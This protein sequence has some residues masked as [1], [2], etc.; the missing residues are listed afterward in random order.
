MTSNGG[1][2]ADSEAPIPH[3]DKMPEITSRP[4]SGRRMQSAESPMILKKVGVLS[5]AKMF[6]AVYA[7]LGLVI[8]VCVAIFSLL[9]SAFGA[10][11]QAG[12][13]GVIFGVGAVIFLPILYGVL[14]F[15]G[16][17]LCAFLY[18]V[19]S[20]ALGGIELELEPNPAA[21]SVALHRPPPPVAPPAPP[22]PGV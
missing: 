7:A 22:L 17:A 19:I 18:N 8:G 16:G 14:G 21:R 20:D 10:T 4:A 12:A 5:C 9:G 2:G 15:L 11:K 13:F 6:G 1:I 3:G